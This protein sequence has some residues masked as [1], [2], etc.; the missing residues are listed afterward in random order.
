MKSLVGLLIVNADYPE[1]NGI[2]FEYGALVLCLSDGSNLVVSCDPEGNG[3][4]ALFGQGPD[5]KGEFEEWTFPTLYDSLDDDTKQ[6]WVRYANEKLA[7]R[8]ILH[9][10]ER[11]GV[12]GG[13]AV[14]A[15]VVAD[16]PVALGQSVHL[17]VPHAVI[18][19]S[20]VKE[21]DGRALPGL[22]VVEASSRH[23]DEAIRLR[24]GGALGDRKSVV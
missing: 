16:D 4:G 13:T 6:R 8:K 7:D 2:G 23:P 14:G 9:V 20:T 1:T 17:G 5:E 22:P 19:V 24:G 18:Q 15:D 21:K 11:D 12:S 3:P 10:R